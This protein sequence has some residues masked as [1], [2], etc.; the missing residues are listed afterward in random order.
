MLARTPRRK[1]GLGNPTDKALDLV[2]R[3]TG[4]PGRGQASER[5]SDGELER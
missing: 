3:V 5:P 1:R 4:E 2:L